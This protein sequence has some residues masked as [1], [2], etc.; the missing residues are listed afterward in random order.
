MAHEQRYCGA[1]Q[2]RSPGVVIAS[3]LDAELIA[4][5]LRRR[6]LQVW[7]GQQRQASHFGQI[8]FDL[9]RLLIDPL[10]LQGLSRPAQIVQPL[11]VERVA[12]FEDAVLRA[13]PH[14]VTRAVATA[15]DI[16]E[17]LSNDV[18][19]FASNVIPEAPVKH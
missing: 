16:G 8:G 5:G 9:G 10:V 6:Q 2:C 15:R 3:N 17:R 7:C 1:L 13:N 14:R 12:E 11:V 19:G 18:P 4:K